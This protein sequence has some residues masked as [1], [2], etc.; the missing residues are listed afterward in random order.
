MEFNMKACEERLAQLCDIV[1]PQKVKE[2]TNDKARY[3]IGQ[4]AG[5]V[6]DTG[7]PTD[8]SEFGVKRADLDVLVDAGSKQQRLLVNN[9][10]SLSLEDI[11][12][13]YLKVLK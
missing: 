10:K 5:I 9:R 7:I 1:Y 8:L 2:S 3:I 11:R 4:I 6:K 13:I 12:N